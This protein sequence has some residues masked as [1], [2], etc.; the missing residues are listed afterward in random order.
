MRAFERAVH[1]KSCFR[2]QGTA[3]RFFV[4]DLGLTGSQR[5]DVATER[6]WE[7][8]CDAVGVDPKEY[9]W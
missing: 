6:T 2:R 9:L 5:N 7:Q 4:E 1:G 3:F 8:I